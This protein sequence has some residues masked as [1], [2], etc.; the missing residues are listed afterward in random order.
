MK[1]SSPKAKKTEITKAK[2]ASRPLSK[3]TTAV[4]KSRGTEMDNKKQVHRLTKEMLS[5]RQKAKGIERKQGGPKI[6]ELTQQKLKTLSTHI[7][8]GPTQAE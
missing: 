6:A 4:A 8:I 3:V 5:K 7:E 1:K 2:K